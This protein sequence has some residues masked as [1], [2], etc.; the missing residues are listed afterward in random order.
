MKKS[1]NEKMGSKVPPQAIEAEKAVLGAMMNDNAV[2]IQVL[3]LLETTDFFLPAH[4]SIYESIAILRQKKQPIDV[5]TVSNEAR[6]RIN[7]VDIGKSIEEYAVELSVAASSKHNV[8]SY[9]QIVLAASTQ[10]KLITKLDETIAKIYAGDEV[11]D[12]MN[13]VEIALRGIR[14]HF[15]FTETHHLSYS[16]NRLN[17]II[18]KLKAGKMM[19]DVM[20]HFRDIDHI[21]GGMMN[22][23][24][25]VV[26][27]PEKI[28]KTTFGL[29]VAMANARRGIGV[30]IFS[31]EMT[32]VELYMRMACIEARIRWLDM[33]N[34]KLTA[35]D[36]DRLNDAVNSLQGLP[37]YINDHNNNILTIEQET[38]KHREAHKIGLLI[39]DYIQIV[40]SIK[41]KDDETREREVSRISS[42]LKQIAKKFDLP[43]MAMSQL[44]KD[45][46]TR[47]SKA[48][49]FDLD[50]WIVL[51]RE[52]DKVDAASLNS[53][54]D[55][56]IV[57]RMG[58]CRGFGTK[59]RPGLQLWYIPDIGAFADIEKHHEETPP[60]GF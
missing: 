51:H 26:S 10:R 29:Q 32:S 36:W 33:L 12:T 13:G 31:Q 46:S 9:A 22:G 57:Q 20:F 40:D 7:E 47:E 2:V 54:V 23:N 58:I 15:E 1:P 38:E 18:E 39:V 52:D 53:I 56:K 55:V 35:E 49:L 8:S 11:V 5:I 21:T 27:A 45:M 16:I 41:T 25:I 44:N 43:V 19:G 30:Q 37:I 4:Q 60:E 24:F 42:G 34:R 6:T 3:S 17:Q 50:K 14:E 28:G 48:I 59:D